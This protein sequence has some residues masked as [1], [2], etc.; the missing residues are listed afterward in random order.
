MV[1][2]LLFAAVAIIEAVAIP[3]AEFRRIVRG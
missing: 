1:R 3:D 2:F